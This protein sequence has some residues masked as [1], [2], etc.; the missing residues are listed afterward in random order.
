MATG[1]WRAP[2][3]WFPGHM[4]KASRQIRE[5]IIKCDVVLEIRDARVP[6]ISANEAFEVSPF[7]N[8]S[9]LLTGV[10]RI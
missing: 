7:V 9:M 3:S 2:I 10:F 4:A 5:R 8:D 1:K 6:L